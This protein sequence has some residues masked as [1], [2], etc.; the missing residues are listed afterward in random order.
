MKF[1]CFISQFSEIYTFLKSVSLKSNLIRNYKS[2][3][4]RNSEIAHLKITA[5]G[6]LKEK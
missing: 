2:W 5:K 4:F 6:D 3:E 1:S